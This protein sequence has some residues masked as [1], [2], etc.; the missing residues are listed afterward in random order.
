MNLLAQPPASVLQRM[1]WCHRE[2]PGP[3]DPAGFGMLGVMASGC[4]GLGPGQSG[5]DVFQG[6]Q[7]RPV[8]SDECVFFCASREV[9]PTPGVA[10]E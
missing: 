7:P 5:G 1:T 6:D 9:R 2:T 3:G 10:K 8:F 4:R